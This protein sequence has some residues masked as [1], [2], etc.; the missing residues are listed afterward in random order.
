MRSIYLL[1][2]S[3]T[4]REFPDDII[5]K[6]KEEVRNDFTFC[7]VAANFKEIEKNK[8]RC[9]KI[10]DMFSEK[11]VKFSTAF[12]VDDSVSKVEAKKYITESNVVF[13]MGGDTLMQIKC[14]KENELIESMQSS[15]AI[16]IGMSAGSINMA[17]NVVLT[18][19]VEDDIPETTCYEGIGL[20]NINVEP[21]CDF[22]NIEHWNDL[23]DASKLSEIICMEDNCSILVR[24][25][26]KEFYGNYCVIK[27]GKIIINNR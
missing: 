5:N 27:D 18:K 10:L 15:N 9:Q 23:L 2:G 26:K 8:E 16:F 11:N 1:S 6:L 19:D 12:I 24:D 21:H 13:L 22:E 7:F 14:I 20:T 4:K 25:G 3:Y 17:K